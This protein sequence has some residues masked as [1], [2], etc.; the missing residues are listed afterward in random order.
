MNIPLDAFY[1]SIIK[2]YDDNNHKSISILKLYK[3]WSCIHY[4][5][6]TYETCMIYAKQ[7]TKTFI[8]KISFKIIS[9]PDSKLFYFIF[10]AVIFLRVRVNQRRTV[11]NDWLT[12][13]Y[14][15]SK[16]VI[17]SFNEFEQLPFN[18]HTHTLFTMKMNL[19]CCN[20][21]LKEKINNKLCNK[22]KILKKGS[23]F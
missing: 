22:V 14:I 13:F 12:F 19:H 18:L 10:L 11:M 6:D 5:V 17:N 7:Q 21:N 16:I 2:A 20:N 15:F 4:Y 1:L 3:K 23:L 8:E 9:S